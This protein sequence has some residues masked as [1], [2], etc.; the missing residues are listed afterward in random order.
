M[1]RARHSIPATW[2]W[3]SQTPARCWPDGALPWRRGRSARLGP[4]QP[5]HRPGRDRP[6]RALSFG[7]RDRGGPLPLEGKADARTAGPAI[8]RAAKKCGAEI[9]TRTEVTDLTRSGT[10]WR[11]TLKT[12]GATEAVSTQT[13]VIPAGVWTTRIG[14]M[15]APICRPSRWH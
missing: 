2:R 11:V 14:A 10:A 5:G 7:S 8:A 3:R 12:D 9:R 6:H 13:I 4:R 1:P 15:M